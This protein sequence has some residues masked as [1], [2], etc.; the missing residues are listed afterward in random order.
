VATRKPPN[1]GKGR[2][3][4]AKNKVSA[5]VRALAQTYTE[6]ALYALVKLMRGQ[7]RPG[8]RAAP[9]PYQTQAYA[10]G[11]IL[12]RGHGKPAQA[13]TGESG[14]GPVTVNLIEELHPVAQL[15]AHRQWR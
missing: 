11:L 14:T 4:G 15:D 7:R 5:D 12:D 13:H 3:K 10:A 2:P 8:R 1:A 9:V 6:E